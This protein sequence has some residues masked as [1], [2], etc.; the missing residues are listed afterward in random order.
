MDLIKASLFVLALATAPL[1]LATTVNLTAADRSFL[2]DAATANQKEIDVSKMAQQ[3][4]SSSAV[5]SFAGTMVRDH[6]KLGVSM[7]A[8]FGDAV[9]PAPSEPP[10][11]LSGKTGK[12]FDKA[13]MDLMVSDHAAV[14]DKFEQASKSADYSKAVHKAAAHALPT[15]KHHAAMAKSIDA[16]V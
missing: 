9:T 8:T 13:Y 10:S 2:S 12:D 4:A 7:K 6:T 15:L 5:K 16:K 1:A 14:Q 11:E 3:Q